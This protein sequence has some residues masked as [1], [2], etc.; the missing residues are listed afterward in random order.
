MRKKPGKIT[1]CRWRW[2]GLVMLLVLVTVAGCATPGKRMEYR[3]DELTPR[4][5]SET[6]S[7]QRGFEIVFE[8]A[9][10]NTPGGPVIRF[11]GMETVRSCMVRQYEKWIYWQIPGESDPSKIRKELAIDE[12]FEL[13]ES[14]T[15]Q[16]HRTG[17]L[18]GSRA[19]INGNSLVLG[20]DGAWPASR[21]LLSRLLAEM[22]RG[23]KHD[24]T[25]I[26][27]VEGR[28]EQ[29]LTVQRDVLFKALGGDRG[30]PTTPLKGKS[31][32]PSATAA[33]APAPTPKPPPAP[34]AVVPTVEMTSWGDEGQTLATLIEITSHVRDAI[35]DQDTKARDCVLAKAAMEVQAW[36]ASRE[37]AAVKLSIEKRL[38][39]T[40]EL[41]RQNQLPKM[42][43]VD[44][45][46]RW[47]KVD[48]ALA[49]D[50]AWR[51][52][53]VNALQ[54]WDKARQ[55]PVNSLANLIQAEALLNEPLVASQGDPR[56]SKAL[57]AIRQELATVQAGPLKP[58]PAPPLPPV[59]MMLQAGQGSGN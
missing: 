7:T 49:K 32:R 5:K 2:L 38:K 3:G 11:Y 10:K 21:E 58:I 37:M 31:K 1:A 13:R 56:V 36:P 51:Q 19:T 55:N 24:T 25:L 33:S 16:T 59:P 47:R 46:D 34:V 9:K 53:V 57:N 29:R 41:F 28:G 30:G 15:E 4:A 20:P 45:Q 43:I 27:Q 26:C 6:M 18:A 39:A 44:E 54:L 8:V 50:L 48:E 23:K 52:L 22:E 40:A 12:T 17:P 35:G 14:E 42:R